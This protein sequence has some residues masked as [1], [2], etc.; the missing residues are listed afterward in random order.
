MS[1]SDIPRTF[2]RRTYSLMIGVTSNS[3]SSSKTATSIRPSVRLFGD[4]PSVAYIFFLSRVP[5]FLYTVVGLHKPKRY[6]E[7]IRHIRVRNVLTRRVMRAHVR[8]RGYMTYAILATR[9]QCARETCNR[10]FAVSP[11]VGI[12]H[13]CDSRNL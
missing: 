2:V 10:T 5:P 3:S 6:V 4:R 1:T 11:S 9:E 12:Y 8:V 13:T 7:S